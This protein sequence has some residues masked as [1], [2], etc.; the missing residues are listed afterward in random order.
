MKRIILGNT[1]IGLL[2]MVMAQPAPVD[3]LLKSAASIPD[4]TAA[5]LYSNIISDL[6][7]QNDTIL[8]LGTGVGL[9]RIHLDSLTLETY[10]SSDDQTD[11]T[12][13]VYVP[14][15][16]VAA[17][18][19][20]GD[21]VAVATAGREDG[22]STGQ[23]L[24][25]SDSTRADWLY[26]EQ[27]MDDGLDSLERWW[28]NHYYEALPITVPQQN[29]TYDASIAGDYLWIASWAGGVRRY[30]FS[31]GTWER[32]PLPLDDEPELITCVDSLYDENNILKDYLLNPRDPSGSGGGDRWKFG[33][34]NHK[35]FA[36]MA[37]GSTIW[38]GTANGINRGTINPV[39]CIDWEHYF[40][41]QDNLSGNWVV[42][43]ARQI[44]DGTEIIWAVTLPVEESEQRG[45]SYTADGGA[46]W[47]TTLIGERAY[48]VTVFDSLIFAA[49]ENGLWRSDDGGNWA[50]Y[51]PA[52]QSI[53][54]TG[55]Q[56]YLTDEITT[57][58]VYYALLDQ[59]RGDLWIG[60]GDGLAV[61]N[62]INGLNWQIF[63]TEFEGDFVYPN[64]F[65][66]G[67]DG[68]QFVRIKVDVKS[69]YVITMDVFN[70]ALQ[71]VCR[72]VYDRRDEDMGTYKWNGCDDN[73]RPVANGTYFIR[74]NY[75]NGDHWLKLIVVK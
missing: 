32:V 22:V 42:G 12:A 8:W 34:H 74:M 47:H 65:I 58:E 51:Q 27:P 17:V 7:I 25:I 36:V 21:R 55:S 40:Y 45:L 44:L 20:A 37:T 10:Y 6:C 46:T 15:G 30:S 9:S 73:G 39:G 70:F 69:S 11:G 14:T 72:K 63:R 66:M 50:L 57:N 4:S 56:I 23:G 54:V 43:L 28:V 33:Q 24:V 71:Q 60:T 1:L 61:T 59:V 13:T 26:F 64:P 2:V 35:G 67:R 68:D 29:V 19:V 16:G 38:V 49:T 31:T 3:F 41:P 62:D 18:A 75:D 48:N 52:R 5:G 53:P